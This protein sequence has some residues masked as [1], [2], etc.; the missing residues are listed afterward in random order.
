MKLVQ[1]FCACL[2]LVSSAQ[3]Q[4]REPREI[5]AQGLRGKTMENCKADIQ[6]LCAPARLKQECLVA[7]WTKLSGDCQ[8]GLATPM[9]GGGE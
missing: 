7:H 6:R 1:A 3:A 4:D 2:L 8:D 9:R 5:P